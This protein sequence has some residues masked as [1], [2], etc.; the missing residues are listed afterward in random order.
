MLA[1]FGLYGSPETQHSWQLDLSRDYGLAADFSAS[2]ELVK[3]MFYNCLPVWA[4]W[5][6]QL[7]SRAE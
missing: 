1:L 3:A 5:N 2:T 4:E 7:L 6:T